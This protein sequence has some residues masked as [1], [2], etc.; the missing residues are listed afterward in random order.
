MVTTTAK[1][2]RGPSTTGV[3]GAAGPSRVKRYQR[4]VLWERMA[5]SGLW[6]L[7]NLRYAFIYGVGLGGRLANLPE[8][9]ERPLL[10]GLMAGYGVLLVLGLL[11]TVGTLQISAFFTLATP[12][13]VGLAAAY[14]IGAYYIVMEYKG[15]EGIAGTAL[16]V[17]L[18]LNSGNPIL[19]LANVVIFAFFILVCVHDWRAVLSLPTRD[20]HK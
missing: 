9:S 19:Q 5:S 6:L 10:S 15:G 14:I 3:F 2:R 18:V 8:R 4:N 11:L 16:I 13:L 20:K 7:L 1:S 17:D 12:I